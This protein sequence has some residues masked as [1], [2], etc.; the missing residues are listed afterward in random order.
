MS[1]VEAQAAPKVLV[2]EDE[3]ALRFLVTESLTGLGEF[4][5]LEAQSADEAVD[6]L[7]MT[8]DIGCV[9]TDVRM[10]GRLNGLDLARFIKAHY[11][12][13]PVIVTSGNLGPAE[14]APGVSFIAK[15]YALEDLSTAIQKMTNRFAPKKR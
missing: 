1:V 7:K 12:D 11:P 10:P 14:M 5:V 2:V 3:P 6:I 15:P 13:V 9:F 8:D 4:I